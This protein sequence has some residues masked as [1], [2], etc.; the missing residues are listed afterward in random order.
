VGVRLP[1]TGQFASK[2]ILQSNAK[3]YGSAHSAL[4]ERI[5]GYIVDRRNNDG[6]YAFAQGLDSNAQDTY[7]GLAV[8]NLLN[9]PFP[10]AQE[11]VKWL[12]GFEP[13]SIYSHY[14]ISK[15]LTLC[16]ERIGDRTERFLSSVIN[17]RRYFGNV[18]VYVEVASEFEFTLMVLELASL[19][20]MTP[21]AKDVKKWLLENKNEDG[22]FGAHKH[23]NIN[24]TYYAVAALSLLK[25]DREE[26][27]STVNF[28]RKCELP[29]GGFSVIPRTGQPYIEYTYYGATALGTLGDNCRFPAQTID[30]L[31]KCQ[32][33]N[34]GFARS[35]LGIS[36]FENTFQAVSILRRLDFL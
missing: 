14:Y 28:I 9:S 13:D 30:F 24:S 35:D 15:A 26:L 3:K 12:R 19:L 36:T 31:L 6:G 17:S 1:E 22:G 21:Q 11:T 32:K 8:L 5:I 33:G 2:T 34:G 4:S 16:N 7:Y 27:S 23:S 29:H 18:D 25:V 10:D 20:K